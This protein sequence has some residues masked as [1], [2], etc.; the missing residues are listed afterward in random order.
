MELSPGTIKRSE[1]KKETR[2]YKE[3]REDRHSLEGVWEGFSTVF[4]HT[5]PDKPGYIFGT[6]LPGTG[7]PPIK[8][9]GV[10]FWHRSGNGTYKHILEGKGLIST[11]RSGGSN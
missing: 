8:D 5:D 9:K 7:N 1:K 10:L 6:M 4:V 3:S 2:E 11:G